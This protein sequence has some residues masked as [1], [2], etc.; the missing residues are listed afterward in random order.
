MPPL[1]RARPIVAGSTG[2]SSFHGLPQDQILQEES[3]LFLQHLFSSGTSGPSLAQASAALSYEAHL[4]DRALPGSN[5][6]VQSLVNHARHLAPP[7]VH[8]QPATM[9][10]LHF[11]SQQAS[12]LG[13]FVA[14]CTFIVSL[15]MFASCS[16]F[17]DIAYLARAAI[18]FFADF[19]HLDL[20]KTKTNQFR[21]DDEKFGPLGNSP[22]ICPLRN[23]QSWLDR[24]DVLKDPD[25]SLQLCGLWRS[26]E[27]LQSYVLQDPQMHLEPAKKIGF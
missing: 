15:T 1:T 7:V 9:E 13:T 4:S 26:Q 3:A 17:S 5:K 27:S 6:V 22:S 14:I 8:K 10:H 24:Q 18:F 16:R 11:L 2:S 21:K 25:D 20:R 19:Y 12:K 23:L